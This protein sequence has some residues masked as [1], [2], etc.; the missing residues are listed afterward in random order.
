MLKNKIFDKM[1]NPN[2]P[3]EIMIE[4]EFKE[5]NDF[6]FALD[7]NVIYHHGEQKQ[8]EYP[9]LYRIYTIDEQNSRAIDVDVKK[10]SLNSNDVFILVGDESTF[11][12]CG[13]YI[14]ATK[15]KAAVSYVNKLTKKDN[16]FTV[17]EE[18][19]EPKEF[20]DLI[21]N[22]GEYITTKMDYGSA[23]VWH[24]VMRE[25]KFRLMQ[26]GGLRET[27]YADIVDSKNCLF[28]QF[29]DKMFIWYPPNVNEKERELAK[30]A[31]SGLTK[32]IELENADEK[33]SIEILDEIS[34]EES[35]L[36]KS[37]FPEWKAKKQYVDYFAIEA[38]KKLQEEAALMKK[39][40]PFL[41][42]LYSKFP[43]MLSNDEL[44]NIT[45]VV[46]LYKKCKDCKDP[47]A[48]LNTLN[49]LPK[50]KKFQFNQKFAE[51]LFKFI[52][53]M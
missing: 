42:V 50:N 30:K 19:K 34:G 13:K 8:I 39:C 40:S 11:F 32:K 37:N 22:E 16:E 5:S 15:K 21:K 48:I 46:F 3:D 51:E 1:S 26:I 9:K 49:K 35:E 38:E 23:I 44:V 29:E 53:N 4:E 33:I 25:D 36:F 24:T 2:H 17:V 43:K 12:W 6:L 28:F 45:N 10:S 52:S 47:S 27:R 41:D 14:D 7:Y 31:A 20:W 18:G